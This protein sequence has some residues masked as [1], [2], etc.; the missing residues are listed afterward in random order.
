MFFEV[1]S[2]PTCFFS[3]FNV[4]RHQT[5]RLR[6]G[7][8]LHLDVSTKHDSSS[9]RHVV[10]LG[11]QVGGSMKVL[12]VCILSLYVGISSNYRFGGF[13]WVKT[14]EKLY[15]YPKNCMGFVEV[16]IIICCNII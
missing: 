11:N 10:F 4:R 2:C 14:C 12:L 9:R 1:V 15:G 13:E 8:S 3:G 5:L 16:I 6:C 7:T